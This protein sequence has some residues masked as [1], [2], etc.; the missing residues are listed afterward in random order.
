MDETPRWGE[1]KD[2]QSPRA[3][4]LT[5]FD[6]MQATRAL[7]FLVVLPVAPRLAAQQCPG[8][9][10]DFGLSGLL[11]D[12]HALASFD[13][14]GG[15]KLY[16][17]GTFTIAE[18]T[19]ARRIAR[20]DGANWSALP[21]DID[22]NAVECLAVFDDGS[23]PALYVGGSFVYVGDANQG[24]LAA[25]GI[26][27]WNGTAWS[28]VGNGLDGTVLELVAHDDGSG[29]KLY[30]G[31][32]FTSSGA[33]PL[34]H[35]A[36][37]DG[38][39]WQGVGG[40]TNDV[41]RALGV[42]DEGAGPR[43]FA[44]G[45]FSVA[46]G[47]PVTRVA[48]WNGT[49]WSALAGSI[50]AAVDV[51]SSWTPAPGA[52]PV[53][54]AGGQFSTLGAQTA[55]GVAQW[56]GTA[57]STLA[58]GTDG[59]VTTFAVFDDGAGPQLH[60]GGPAGLHRWNGTAWVERSPHWVNT[61]LVHDEG[62]GGGP[63]LFSGRRPTSTGP[64]CIVRR[65]GGVE[66]AV[67]NS[68]APDACE[69]LL[70]GTV[71]GESALFATKV[72]WVDD[73]YL[74]PPWNSAGL[75]RFEGNT[76]TPLAA[77]VSP[78]CMVRFDLLPGGAEE[79]CFGGSFAFNSNLIA[80]WDGATM[81]LVGAGGG[82][83]RAFALF[84]SGGGPELYATGYFTSIEGVPAKHIARFSGGVWS[85][86]G[87]GLDWVSSSGE[88]GVDLAVFDDGGGPALYVAGSFDQA[89]GVS[90]PSKVARWNGTTWSAVGAGATVGG[91][92]GLHVHA[93]ALHAFGDFSQIGG[94]PAQLVARWSGSAWEPLGAGLPGYAVLDLATF[95][96]G[97]GGGAELHA[98]IA[99]STWPQGPSL[100]RYDGTSWVPTSEPL[101]G[102]FVHDLVA[103]DADHDGA[104]EL[105][106]AGNFTSVGTRPARLLAR[107]DPCG[108]VSSFCAGDGVDAHVTTACPCGNVGG[109]G[110]GCAWHAGPQG[111]LLAASGTTNPDALVLTASGMPA[112]APSTIF[113]KGDVLVAGGVVFGDGVRC[114]GGNLIRLGTKTNVGGAAQYPEAGNAAISVRGQTPVGSGAIGYYQTYYRNAA[115][116]C[117]SS[118]F[119]VTN[120]VRVVW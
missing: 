2:P 59:F 84:D 63:A 67:S 35:L 40:G 113:L 81:T 86:L 98:G 7:A 15:A 21:Q 119:N 111:A 102:G 48:R 115:V 20:W 6:A 46:G 70:D 95:D 55:G 105:Y 36:R 118:T 38:S 27:R 120:A 75:A 8:W 19:F 57:W 109:V 83:L 49:A 97:S 25:P 31:G 51:L 47:V 106:A 52:T 85:A 43:L 62:T 68:L 96:D 42:H 39:A 54:L 53:L 66:T 116:F 89:G 3:R 11:G 56:N 93:G 91:V 87:S 60:A 18:S 100:L 110:R 61:L 50:P 107:L 73:A 24:Q 76:W 23:G 14:G 64:L 44:G 78:L 79:L 41:V 65:R 114:V 33:T 101:Q 80:V 16:A 94:V 58:T 4:D 104:K 1:D 29:L 17:G 32:T 12:V 103:F 99:W 112:S 72:R 9:S 28:A 71:A 74:F 26:A 108:P 117:T 88:N 5:S 37:W 10:E 22:H 34:A 30:A 69:R 45:E 90:C 82:E 77:D 92:R 13:D